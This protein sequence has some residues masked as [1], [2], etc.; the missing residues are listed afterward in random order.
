M[1]RWKKITF[2]GLPTVG[3]FLTFTMYRHFAH[4][5]D[6]HEKVAYPHLKIRNKPF[7]WGS[8]DC[9]LFDFACKKAAYEEA[10]AQ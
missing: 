8:K 5:H 10:K 3:L 9:D 2:V 7:P 4:H 6:D 1:E